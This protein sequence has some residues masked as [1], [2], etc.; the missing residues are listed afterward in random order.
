MEPQQSVFSTL[1][2]S[3]ERAEIRQLLLQPPSDDAANADRII[4]FLRRLSL[5]DAA[6]YVALSYVWG[7]PDSQTRSVTL[8]GQPFPVTENLHD[9]LLH[10]RKA[11][12]RRDLWIDAIC[13]NQS[14]AEEKTSQVQLMR[15]IYRKA[16]AVIIW[17][18]PST[19]ATDTALEWIDKIGGALLDI[20]LWELGQDELRGWDGWL[21]EGRYVFAVLFPTDLKQRAWFTR[22]WCLQ[23]LANA[24][25]AILRCGER[26]VEYT[27]L[28]A[29]M[30]F[31]NIFSTWAARHL[32][33]G[34]QAI[35]VRSAR[36][37]EDAVDMP[38]VSIG[39]RRKRLKDP[40]H[41]EL[42]LKNLLVRVN[43]VK[44]FDSKG[45]QI[46]AT[47]PKERVYALLG[48][49]NEL[50]AQDIVPDY[51]E[52]YSVEEAYVDTAKALL[53]HG[54]I[55]ILALCRKRKE[56]QGLPSWVPDWT[57][58]NRE[59]SGGSSEKK[60]FSAGRV[61]GRVSVQP[62]LRFEGDR[63]ELRGS[64]VD[65]I[66]D[67]GATW[68]RGI[69]EPFDYDAAGKVFN[70][71][72]NFL[73]RSSS[74]W[75]IPIGDLESGGVVNWPQRATSTA[76]DGYDAIRQAVNDP[77]LRGR[78]HGSSH[79][80][81]LAYMGRMERIYDSRPF[82]SKKGY[83]GLCPVDADK[84][85]VIVV[86]LSAQ[87]PFVV[88]K[89]EDR[90]WRLVGEAHVFGIMDGEWMTEDQVVEGIVLR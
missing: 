90:A 1:P 39:L 52:A 5:E 27:R 73:S 13:I 56:F 37:L 47:Y 29:T 31:C 71:I 44:M 57:A 63:L 81:F 69:A 77:A 43:T 19:P 59:P 22:A 3:K 35:D 87:V 33:T 80:A 78:D 11:N 50:V 62:E 21:Q 20:G 72:A 7:P 64:F 15:H 2:L 60:W 79:A 6:E 10:L 14:D 83:V 85:D 66:A 18:G 38:T 30:Y 17:L 26:E 41:P 16:S 28:W 55:D 54:N 76:K 75:R 70:D 9:A 46:R 88:R 25:V 58:D 8:N 89:R 32:R 36:I 67:L 49:A 12:D 53:R 40:T 68:S 42:R 61:S 74:P 84:E 65:V 34:N 24:C 48:I 45:T 51:S 23:E 86:I 82:L 4:C